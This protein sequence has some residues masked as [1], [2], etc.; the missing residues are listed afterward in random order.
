VTHSV[1]DAHV[2]RQS[3]VDGSHVRGEQGVVAP[4]MQAPP[5]LQ[6]FA[7]RDALPGSHDGGA[8]T[9]FAGWSA[10]VRLPLQTP[11]FAHV[12]AASVTHS[13]SGSSPGATASQKPARV[14]R[15]HDSQTPRQRSAQH[16]P[17]WQKPLAHSVSTEHCWPRDFLQTGATQSKPGAQSSFTPQAERQSPVEESQRSGEQLCW[18][19]PT[20]VPCPLQV[21]ARV[22]TVSLHEA[23]TQTVPCG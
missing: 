10:H 23:G 18:P 19:L 4:T 13:L 21:L 17:S 14:G 12:D 3:P 7:A 5:P 11:V 9:V 8:Q 2:E 22:E 1:F 6:R 15:L 16:T 20:H